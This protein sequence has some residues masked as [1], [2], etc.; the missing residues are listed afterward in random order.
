[1]PGHERTYYLE[2]LAVGMVFK[3]PEHVLDQAQ[4]IAFASAFDPQPFHLDEAAAKDTFFG[5]IVASG[6]HTAA[7]TMRL[8]VEGV[9][10]AGGVIGSG[11]EITWPRPTRPN[12]RLHVICEVTQI[13]PSKTRPERGMV[14]AHCETRTHQGDVVQLFIPKLLVHRRPMAITS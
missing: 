13:I 5:E 2:D 11:G 12:D 3:S 1:M 4:V 7:I 9:P 8:L 6:W 14:R 10:I